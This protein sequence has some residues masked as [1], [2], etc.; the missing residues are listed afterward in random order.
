MSLEKET[1]CPECKQQTLAPWHQEGNLVTCRNPDCQAIISSAGGIRVGFLINK[2]PI[3]DTPEIKLNPA[4]EL[5]TTQNRKFIIEFSL[6]EAIGLIKILVSSSK[7][8]E[9]SWELINKLESELRKRF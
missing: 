9:F 7:N 6:A 8:L 3:Y 4:I 2:E 1:I 5:D